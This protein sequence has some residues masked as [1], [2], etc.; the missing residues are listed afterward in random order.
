[1]QP[2]VIIMAD[3]HPM[4]RKAMRLTLEFH[5]GCTNLEMCGVP[6]CNQLMKELQKKIFTH[7][8]LDINLSD[9]CSLEILPNI[10][11]LYPR[12]QIL[13]FSMQPAV[14]YEKALKQY[15]IDFYVSKELPEEDVLK[16]LCQFLHNEHPAPA[17]SQKDHRSNPFSSLSPRELEV[18]H[19]VL[20]GC[21]SNEIART[22]NLK[23]TTIS[24]HKREIFNKTQTMNWRNLSDLA[25]LYNF[26]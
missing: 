20:K 10:R 17:N 26:K 8:I 16:L 25:N 15:N 4:M 9:G 2:P 13:V 7:L 1:M 24:T 3:D 12:L 6:S 21:G 11:S 23:I 19:Y 22:L 18:L 14:I 5:L